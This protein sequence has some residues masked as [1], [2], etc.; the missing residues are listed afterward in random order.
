M[1]RDQFLNSGLTLVNCALTGDPFCGFKKG[2]YY[3]ITGDSMTGKSIWTLQLF[4]EAANDPIFDD[5]S[6][7]HD[8]PEDGV[9]LDVSEVFGEKTATRIEEYASE[10]AEEMYSK[11]KKH[12][13]SGPTLG[14]V[15]SMDALTTLAELK[16]GDE[17]ATAIEEG[18]TTTGIMSDGKAK[19]NSSN[20]RQMMKPLKDTGSF[21]FIIS[22]TRDSVGT[23]FNPKTRSGGRALRFYAQTEIWLSNKKTLKKTVKGI[24]REVGQVVE[25]AVKKTRHSSFKTKVEVQLLNDYGFDDIGSC[26]DW[27][28]QNK[29]WSGGKK[30]KAPEFKGEYSRADLIAY[31]EEK[32]V[33][34]E[35]LR[36]LVGKVWTEIRDAI[37]P[38]RKKRY[39]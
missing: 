37:R 10:T 39:N 11:M 3:N 15:D 29:H 16:K 26:V 21:L 19:V 38:D 22:Q 7:Q 12:M 4:A 23:G 24:D 30:I 25:F 8:N 1:D 35:K 31:I 14:V 27:L 36:T 20:L 17:I 6:F 9:H 18:S 32:E 28:I 33:R 34:H 13:K 5:Y 2:G